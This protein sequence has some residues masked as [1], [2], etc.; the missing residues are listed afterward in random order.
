MFPINWFSWWVNKVI[1]GKKPIK[2]LP[3]TIEITAATTVEDAKKQIAKA[4][5]ISDFNRV[6]ILDVD[7]QAI[8][9]DRNALLAQQQAVA[10]SYQILVKDLGAW[11]LRY[12]CDTVL[13]LCV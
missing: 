3:E 12:V 9:K 13:S 8:F 4:A 7:K 11:S 10:D 5:G 6:A 2:K 1:A